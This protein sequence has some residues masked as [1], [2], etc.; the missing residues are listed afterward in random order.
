MPYGRLGVA[1][2]SARHS[3]SAGEEP[4]REREN[5]AE[6]HTGMR[7]HCLENAL[8]AYL[9][10]LLSSCSAGCSSCCLLCYDN[11]SCCFY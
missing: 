11:D 5:L 9:M 7:E 6:K 1:D 8:S 3:K 4:E 2:N 10:S